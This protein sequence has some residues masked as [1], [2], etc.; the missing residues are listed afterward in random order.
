M[1]KKGKESPI[2]W[3]APPN[4][5]TGRAL[6]VKEN[7]LNET[8]RAF[9]GNPE[10]ENSPT[11]IKELRALENRELTK[12]DVEPQWCQLRGTSTPRESR[13]FIEIQPKK[14]KKILFDK[15][16]RSSLWDFMETEGLAPIDPL[17]FTCLGSRLSSPTLLLSTPDWVMQEVCDVS[18]ESFESCP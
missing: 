4:G 17:N 6:Y 13:Y 1:F 7:C 11:E 14:N 3:V 9:D 18:F 8:I 5:I 2:V 15:N 16:R 12:W 10:T